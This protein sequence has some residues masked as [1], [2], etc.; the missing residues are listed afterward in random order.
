MNENLEKVNYILETLPYI[1]K[2]SGKTIVIK[3]GGAAMAKEDLKESFAKDIVL[4]KYLGI[5]PIVVHGGGPE[6]NLMVGKLGLSTEFVRGHRITDAPTMEVV[7][8]ILTG[9]VNQQIVSRINSIGGQAVGIS[10]RDGKLA[11]AEKEPLQFE[12]ENGRLETVDIGLV[13]KIHT[14]NTDILSTLQNDG[15]IPVVSPVAESSSGEPLNINADT[16]AG[17]LAGALK[18]EK[19]ILLTDTPGIL[20]ENNLVT[21]LSKE[22]IESYIKDKSISGGM[23]PKVESCLNAIANGVKRSHIIDGRIPHSILLEIFTDQGIGSLIE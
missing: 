12:N 16:M 13:G 3:Y 18:A 5:H 20:I 6:I 10:G 2:F 23:I 8:M 11:I 1:A 7:E 9:K 22:K 21:G 17:M 14:I 4:L 15:F 19:L